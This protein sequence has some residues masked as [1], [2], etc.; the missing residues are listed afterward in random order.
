[1]QPD[2]SR[3]PKDVDARAV[4]A[5]GVRGYPHAQPQAHRV[6][7]VPLHSLHLESV[8]SIAV[9]HVGLTGS[10][11]KAG[12]R[13][14]VERRE[15][16]EEPRGPT[17]GLPTRLFKGLHARSKQGLCPCELGKMSQLRGEVIALDD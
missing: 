15:A 10:E 6:V 11:M 2:P 7:R 14:A 1:M 17:A 5:E 16:A 9:R 12:K 3:L 13:G 4:L 8:R